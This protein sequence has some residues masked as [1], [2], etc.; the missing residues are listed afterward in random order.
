[1]RAQVG[2]GITEFLPELIAGHHCSEDGVIAAQHRSGSRKIASFYGL[3]NS[4]TAN[5]RAIHFHWR[6][7]NNVEMKLRTKSFQQIEIAAPVFS[8]RPF[9]SDANFAQRS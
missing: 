2:G 8:K 9:I 3:P 4:C 6:N 7:P 5:N 1:M